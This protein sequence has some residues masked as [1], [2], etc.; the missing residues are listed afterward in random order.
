[1]VILN[2]VRLHEDA[3]RNAPIKVK[4]HCM[5]SRTRPFARLALA[6]IP[7]ALLGGIAAA[8]AYAAAPAGVVTVDSAISDPSADHRARY[9]A[10]GDSYASGFGLEPYS[11]LPAAGCFQS[12]V[13]Y[14]HRV[15]DA[16]KLKLTDVSCAGAVTANIV[17]TPQRTPFGA[18][19]PVQSDALSK[20]TEIVTL[21]ISGNDLGFSTVLPQCLAASPVGP[22]LGAPEVPNCEAVLAPG[23]NDQLAQKLADEVLPALHRTL[24][25]IAEKAPFAVITVVGYPSIFP[26]PEH[27]PAE[28]CFVSAIGDGTPPF[29]EDAF[30]FTDVDT[31]YFHRTQAALESALAMVAAEHDATFVP[32]MARSAGHEPCASNPDAWVSGLTF[33]GL[34]PPEVKLC[35]LHPNEAGVAFLAEQVAAAITK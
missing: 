12:E 10:L 23:G 6:T 4:E 13:D 14:P 30:P 3:G 2:V 32:A 20:R 5:S 17:D 19:A 24:D 16:L 29:P 27:T 35:G 1:M 22:L 7:I 21:N 28:G 8:P 26:S 11:S 18:L 25:V 9:V 31:A 34:T 33:T 15:A